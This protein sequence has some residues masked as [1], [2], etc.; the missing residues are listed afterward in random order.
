[1][2]LNEIKKKI[3]VFLILID[4]FCFIMMFNEQMILLSIRMKKKKMSNLLGENFENILH[5]YEPV[6]FL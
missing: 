2:E 3:K 4:Q 1:M 5:R 6:P